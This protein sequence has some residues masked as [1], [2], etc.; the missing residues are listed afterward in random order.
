MSSIAKIRKELEKTKKTVKSSKSPSKS[1]IKS[2]RMT[3]IERKVINKLEEEN[4]VVRAENV[5]KQYKA[6]ERLRKNILKA[7]KDDPDVQHIVDELDKFSREGDDNRKLYVE[8]LLLA[9]SNKINKFFSGFLNYFENTENVLLELIEI[10]K[11]NPKLLKNY[12]KLVEKYGS[13]DELYQNE[14]KKFSD[15]AKT[16]MTKKDLENFERSM[17]RLEK[18]EEKPK[19][20][21]KMLDKD[22]NVVEEIQLPKIKGGIVNY[23][24]KCMD[25]YNKKLW[26]PNFSGKY[27]V[28]S[29]INDILTPPYIKENTTIVIDGKNYDEGTGSLDLLLCTGKNKNQEKNVLSV[30][31]DKGRTFELE[32][33]YKLNDNTFL[34]QDEDLY[35]KELGW[36]EKQKMSVYQ[37]VEQLLKEN[38]RDNAIFVR[39]LGISELSKFFDRESAELLEES[40]FTDNEDKTVK[41]YLIGIGNLI[42]FLDDNYLKSYAKGFNEKLANNFFDLDKVLS[43]STKEILEDIYKN[44]KNSKEK[45]EK[46]NNEIK[47]QLNLYIF[48]KGKNIILLSDVTQKTVDDIFSYKKLGLVP[49]KFS[50]CFNK[51]LEGSL[52]TDIVYYVE[53]DKIYCFK[54]LNL[55]SR[56]AKND[57]TNP[58]TGNKFNKY[59][60]DEVNNFSEDK[61]K[62][63]Y[64]KELFEDDDEV[65][66]IVL[67]VK[68]I[69]AKNFNN[70]EYSLMKTIPKNLACLYYKKYILEGD[71]LQSLLQKKDDMLE[72]MKKFCNKSVEDLAKELEEMFDLENS[73]TQEVIYPEEQESLDEIVIPE[74]D[75]EV[76]EKPLQIVKKS[77]DKSKKELVESLFSRLKRI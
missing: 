52:E 25:G 28:R 74:E 9:P 8:L 27:Y 72:D 1:P 7:L 24:K 70:L 31:N 40:N 60:I 56:F 66:E 20:T 50:D 4:D 38:L 62:D 18:K 58:Y 6:E 2:P 30:T 43:I 13:I 21:V 45:I 44:P 51:D 76:V 33:V 35:K 59:F 41:D 61:I 47:N 53:N 36:I 55:I 3:K 39:Q 26:V 73:D 49:L 54:I 16:F 34:I 10:V 75:E 22:G 63:F 67:P 69:L 19:R 11:D 37:K 77:E 71:K 29:V 64:D 12:E 48:N 17:K 46:L 32:I 57:F 15:F 68:N 5:R 65:D 42:I 23:A 14:K